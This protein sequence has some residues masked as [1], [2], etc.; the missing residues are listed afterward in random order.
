MGVYKQGSGAVAELPGFV[1]G[2]A[3]EAEVGVEIEVE[4][5]KEMGHK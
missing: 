2:V 3:V 5:H 1:V 4:M